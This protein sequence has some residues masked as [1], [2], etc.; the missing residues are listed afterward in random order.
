M[1]D[2]RVEIYGIACSELCDVLRLIEAKE[3][4]RTAAEETIRC[5]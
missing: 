3:A 4:A 1:H 5:R 2:G